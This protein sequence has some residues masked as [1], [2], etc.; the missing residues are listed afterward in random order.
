MK[1]DDG[2]LAAKFQELGSHLDY[3]M[4]VVTTSDGR[5]R[6]G[7][8]VGF[9]TQCAI[10]PPL[11]VVFLSNKNFTYRVARRAA[12]LGVHVVPA[13]AEDLARL[14]GEQTGDDIDKFE[15]CRW[16][17]DS[18]GVPVLTDC[19]DRFVGRVRQRVEAGDHA[20]FLLDPV[21]VESQGGPFFAFQRALAFEPG[22]EA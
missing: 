14:F 11:F 2:S 5:R 12:H 3:P 7:C 19:G 18:H 1:K 16:Q 13:D 17:E 10:D 21:T 4:L 9:A 8:L 22:H 6:A 15:H 20:G